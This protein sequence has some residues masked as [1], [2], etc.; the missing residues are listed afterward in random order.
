VASTVT[1]AVASTV[2]TTPQASDTIR[3]P[4]SIQIEHDEIHDALARAIAAPGRVG[5]AARVLNSVL[6]PHFRREEEIALPPLGLLVPLSR[7]EYD[8]EMLDV[9]PLTDSLRAE[10]P[11]MLRQHTEIHAAAARLE[12]VATEAGDTATAS[13]ARELILHAR[14]EEQVL[15]PAAILVGEVVRARAGEQG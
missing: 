5:E 9:L 6:E 12:E 11:E 7:G 13:F 4:S 10:M 2:A 14:T 3:V 8:P 15:Y 1:A